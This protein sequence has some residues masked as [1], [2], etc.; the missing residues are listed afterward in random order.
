MVK[1][2]LPYI[3]ILF[4]AMTSI[5]SNTCMS[6]DFFN[7]YQ[8]NYLKYTFNVSDYMRQRNISDAPPGFKKLGKGA[9]GVVSEASLLVEK[10]KEIQGAFKAIKYNIFE[11]PLL[12]KELSFFETFAPKYPL[13]FIKYY[14]CVR[15]E[16]N[17]SV[18]IF[19]EKLDGS[20]YKKPEKQQFLYN[21]QKNDKLFKMFEN[22]PLS[23]KIGLLLN[24]A[25]GISLMHKEGYVHYDIKP[26]NF[27]IKQ[28][29]YPIIKVIDYGMVH[30]PL[31]S[32]EIISKRGT[33]NYMDPAISTSYPLNSRRND[34]YSLG[35]TFIE[36]FYNISFGLEKYGVNGD[37]LYL[38]LKNVSKNRFKD[39]KN[40]LL[41]AE[42]TLTICETPNEMN[43]SK[44]DKVL[45]ALF[46]SMINS[47]I[48]ERPYAEEIVITLTYILKKIDPESLYLPENHNKLKK[49]VYGE[50]DL[51]HFPV[52]TSRYNAEVVHNLDL[53]Y[54]KEDSIKKYNFINQNSKQ[55]V[56]DKIEASYKIKE[57]NNN[58]NGEHIMKA[59]VDHQNRFDAHQ[60]HKRIASLDSLHPQNFNNIQEINKINDYNKGVFANNNNA[61]GSYNRY[62]DNKW[63]DPLIQG[64][65]LKG[66]EKPELIQ[67]NH[68]L[69]NGMKNQNP[70]ILMHDERRAKS[71]DKKK[72]I[73]DNVKGN[74][75]NIGYRLD[76]KMPNDYKEKEFD[77]DEINKM[78]YPHNLGLFNNNKIDEKLKQKYNFNNPN[79]NGAMQHFPGAKP[80]RAYI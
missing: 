9:F 49:A 7:R 38:L 15:D 58:K 12:D 44:E 78:L 72:K 28:G 18:L 51:E 71:S 35:M 56:L 32:R 23:V 10:K 67:H 62:P 75:N 5:F 1:K 54:L 77:K 40:C 74:S 2:I 19:T 80:L 26:D 42:N 25:L 27:L 73:F 70:Y 64:D 31:K 76:L 41:P 24:M 46:I 50:S 47:D 29:K 16:I 34:I 3:F 14:N 13:F 53:Q 4:F 69:N 52:I 36:I 55:Y 68:N 20:L 60:R 63:Y 65:N 21:M 33:P 6:V 39:Y 43:N 22:H 37:N 61:V 17:K 59:P 30:N 8:S 45:R 11:K 48:K 79:Q 57:E 66:K